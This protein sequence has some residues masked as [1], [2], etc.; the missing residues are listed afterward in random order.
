MANPALFTIPADAS[1]VTVEL[2]R[3]NGGSIKQR[4]TVL[5]AMDL[6][7]VI[8]AAI[9]GCNRKRVKV[10]NVLRIT[11]KEAVLFDAVADLKERMR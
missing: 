5:G 4:V 9:R 11:H 6:T 1:F 3:A 8:T 7:R 2:A 10:G